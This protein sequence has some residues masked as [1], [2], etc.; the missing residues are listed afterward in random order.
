MGGTGQTLEWFA[1]LHKVLAW[2]GV[3]SVG[4][5]IPQNFGMG[6]KQYSERAVS[7]HY[8]VIRI[9]FFRSLGVL[10]YTKKNQIFDKLLTV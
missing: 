6:Q 2:T 7:F 10:F 8:I 5:L 4:G 3:G 9:Y 1:W